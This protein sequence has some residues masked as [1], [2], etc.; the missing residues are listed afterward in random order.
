MAL[1]SRH[2]AATSSSATSPVH[3]RLKFITPI[4]IPSTSFFSISACRFHRTLNQL[5]C[6][7]LPAQAGSFI[8]LWGA[9]ALSDKALHSAQ[10]MFSSGD[11]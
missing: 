5:W 4:D 8:L 9:L 1:P 10:C 6:R 2:C 11:H 3:R 7:Q